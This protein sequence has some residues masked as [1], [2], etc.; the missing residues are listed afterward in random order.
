MV[1]V[2]PV[3]RRYDD[4]HVDWSGKNPFRPGEYYASSAEP[5]PPAAPTGLLVAGPSS[6]AGDDSGGGGSG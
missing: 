1:R 3:P 6:C 4:T 2:R 5:L